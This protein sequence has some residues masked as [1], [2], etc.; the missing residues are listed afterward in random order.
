MCLFK[1]NCTRNNF[2]TYYWICVKKVKFWT[3]ARVIYNLH[4]C[5]NFAFVLP[6]KRTRFFSQSDARNFLRKKISANGIKIDMKR[7]NAN[8]VV[9]DS[10]WKLKLSSTIMTVWTG[11]NALLNFS[12]SAD[13]SWSRKLDAVLFYGLL[14]SGNK[15]SRSSETNYGFIKKGSEEKR[16]RRTIRSKSRPLEVE[17]RQDWRTDWPSRMAE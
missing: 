12:L 15:L 2:V 3:R 11:L 13:L 1:P 9:N 4:T 14:G 5:Y 10:E 8:L 6:Q 17:W 16:K 7:L